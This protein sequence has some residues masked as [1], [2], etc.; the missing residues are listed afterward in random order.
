MKTL[1]MSVL[2]VMVALFI[3]APASASVIWD[4]TG[5]LTSQGYVAT[6]SGA[7]QWD[8]ENGKANVGT[9]YQNSDASTI[10]AYKLQGATANSELSNAAGWNVEARVQTLSGSEWGMF[11]H[12]EDS[13]GGIGIF[14]HPSNIACFK[15]DWSTYPTPAATI[16]LSDTGY[17][18][19]A[20]KV[21]A[22][23][24]SGHVWVDGVDSA[25]VA[26]GA[27]YSGPTVLIG[28]N[29]SGSAGSANWDYLNVNPVPSPEPTTLALL[30]TGLLGLL[31]YAW[32]KR[33]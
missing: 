15:G 7:F 23:A 8:T 16:A 33:K 1:L 20:I 13:V 18:T 30:A 27:N 24:T 10:T 19:I 11:M 6:S 29:S 2:V 31:C 25:T 21:A 9:A 12:A 32:R 17:H 14:L 22:G 5:S 4:G 26:L 3:A 28:D